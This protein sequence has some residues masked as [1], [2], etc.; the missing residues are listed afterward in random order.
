M[1]G[2][3]LGIGTGIMLGPSIAWVHSET[4]ATVANWLA[5]PGQLFLKLIQMI[6]IPLIFTSIIRGLSLASV[7]VRFC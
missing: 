5:F 4:A 2:M 7:V 6:V 1:I 3:V